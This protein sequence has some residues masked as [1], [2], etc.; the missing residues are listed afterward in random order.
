MN[1]QKCDSVPDYMESWGI[2]YVKAYFLIN[3]VLCTGVI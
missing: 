1:A 2:G 3:M